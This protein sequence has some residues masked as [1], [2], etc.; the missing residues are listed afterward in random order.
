MSIVQTLAGAIVSS[1][2]FIQPPSVYATYGAS[3]TE[4]FDTAITIEV[5]NWIGARV[6]WTIVG[7]GSPAA[8][9]NTDMTG[10][11]S[12]YWDPGVTTFAAQVVTSVG[13]VADTTTEGTEYWGINVGSSPGASDY[14]DSG[15]WS[16]TD[17]SIAVPPFSLEFVS[18]QSDYLELATSTDFN[19]GSTWTIEFWLKANAKSETA[20]GGIWGLLNQGGWGAAA[21]IVVALSDNKLVFLSGSS[22]N[23]DVRYVEPTPGTWTHVAIVNNT[24]TQTVWYNG[25]EQVKVSGTFGTASYT[26]STAP[27]RIGRLSPPNGGTLDGKM[28]LVRVSN[29]AKYASAFTPVT[30]YGAEADTKLFFSLDAPLVNNNAN[31]LSSPSNFSTAPW[32]QGGSTGLNIDSATE[33]A[34]DGTYT[35]YQ[36]SYKSQYALTGQY[37]TLIP[38]ETYTVSVYAKSTTAMAIVVND[39]PYTGAWTFTNYDLLNGNVDSFGSEGTISTSI[40][41]DDNGFYLCSATFIVPAGK[42][43]AQVNFF[44]GGYNGADWTGNTMTLWRPS[45]T[46]SPVITNNGVTVSN[47]VPGAFAPLS[48]SFNGSTN[49]L[50]VASGLSDFNLGTTWTMEFWSK[51]TTSSTSNLFTVMSQNANS[52]TIDVFYQNGS[53]TVNNGRTLCAEP[54]PGAWTHVA[55]VCTSTNLIVYYNGV[56]VYIGG[57]YSV[58]DTANTLNI[59][60]RGQIPYQ[61]FNGKLAMIRISNTDK[62]TGAFTPTTSYGV[63]TDTIL[64]LGKAVPLIDAKGHITS[65]SGVTVNTDFPA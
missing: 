44:L 49:Y 63:E 55:L 47:D 52:N 64:F 13:F 30:T 9:P 10:T 26:N 50:D 39:I 62:Y 53:L 38:G 5:S 7:K 65:N 37:C 54:T 3:P 60:K 4:G 17:A 58:S 57:A 19:L 20:G 45:L 21:S 12:G 23:A 32:F 56:A 24:G 40:I 59:G 34:P 25:S 33:L 22:G 51:A 29:T 41:A 1:G 8:D 35:A 43:N 48:S 18:S 61:Y 6:Y 16:I 2:S 27:L 11:L 28:A 15:A 46:S 31:L 42:P 14:Y 36:L